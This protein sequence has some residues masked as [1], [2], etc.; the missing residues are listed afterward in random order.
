MEEYQC[1]LVDVEGQKHVRENKLIC[2]LA[3]KT[4]EGIDMSSDQR[5]KHRALR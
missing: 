2:R 4:E 5:A 1:V 3:E